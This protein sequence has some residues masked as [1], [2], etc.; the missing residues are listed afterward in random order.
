MKTVSVVIP[1]YNE[2]GNINELVRVVDELFSTQVKDYDYELLFIDN[3]SVDNT[4]LLI[5]ENAERNK[6]VKAI[7][8]SANFGWVKSPIHG[9]REATGDCAILITADFQDPFDLIPVMIKEWENG[10]KVVA[11]VKSSSKESKMRYFIRGIYYKMMERLSDV[12]Q[13]DQFTGFGLYDRQFLNALKKLDDPIPYLKGIVPEIGFKRKE[14]YYQQQLRKKGFSKSSF[15]RLFDYAM[16][17]ITSSTK[18]I[19]RISSFLGFII[20]FFSILAA[21]VA[22]ILKLLNWTNYSMGIASL[23][24]GVFFLGGVQLMFMGLMGEYIMSINQRSMHRP[25]VIEEE[26][27]NF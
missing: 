5:R 11:A 24:V 19:M 18:G 7:F 17:G 14:I 23:T 3:C 1:T 6:H 13:I 4:R 26:R 2:E 21:I 12:H 15:W 22:I 8:N 20:S 16:L 10:Y 27:I 25:L 9:L